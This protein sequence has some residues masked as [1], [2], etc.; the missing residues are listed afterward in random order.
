[1][2]AGTDEELLTSGDDP[3]GV[4]SPPTHA[5]AES[6]AE[7]LI[8]LKE[9]AY[10]YFERLDMTAYNEDEAELQMIICEADHPMTRAD[11]EH[12][13]WSVA[14]QIAWQDI[15]DNKDDE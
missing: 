2:N 7:A 6:D 11:F 14:Q 1:M 4:P 13:M 15:N 3:W 9:C 12:P 5:P 8:R 10:S